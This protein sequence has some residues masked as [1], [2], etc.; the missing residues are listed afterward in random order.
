MALKIKIHMVEGGGTK[1]LSSF[2]KELAKEDEKII[3][4]ECL[5]EGGSG[6]KL[7]RV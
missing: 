1:T 7:K 6:M 5:M 4:W 3:L 2:I